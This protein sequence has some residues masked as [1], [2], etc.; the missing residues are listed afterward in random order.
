MSDMS[1]VIVPKSDQLNSDDLLASP[2]TI[3]I[4]KVDIRPGTEQPV[5]VFFEGDNGKPWKCCKSMSRVL[6]RCWG[7]DSANYIGRSLTL[8]RDDKVTWGGVAVG[9]IRISHMSDIDSEIIVPLT[10]NRRERKPYQVKPLAN[11]SASKPAIN[12]APFDAAIKKVA[13]CLTDESL[14][15]AIEESRKLKGWPKAKGDEM[16]KAIESTKAAIKENAEIVA[17]E[18]LQSERQPGDE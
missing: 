14:N 7:K 11:G 1:Q 18:K 16:K 15:A 4:T 13:E 12:I 6:V 2:R 10:A 8:Y 9:G 5:S 3:T 17:N